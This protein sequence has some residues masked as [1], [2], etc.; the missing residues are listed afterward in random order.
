MKQYYFLSTLLPPLS[1]D[2]A[3]E[4]SFD[5]LVISL[6]DNLSP[7]DA[8]K[9]CEIRKFYDILNLRAF[10][11]GEEIDPR[12][13]MNVHELEEAIASYIGFPLY[14]YQFLENNPN[15]ADRI[16]HFPNL[17]ATF[18]QQSQLL[19]DPFLRRYFTFE[20]ALRLVLTAFRAKK[21]KKNFAEEFMYEDP[22]EELI[23]QLLAMQN[24][25]QFEP[26]EAFLGLKTL[27]EKFGNSPLDL[28]REIDRFRCETIESFI[29]PCDFFSTDR[30]LA[31]FAEYLIIEPWF[32]LD[33]DQGKKII[34]TLFKGQKA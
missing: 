17:L 11:K 29:D 26:P 19:K 25:P 23:A 31:Y 3:P 13:D 21:L 30:I 4:I 12:G 22:S 5:E 20:R 27:F 9:I 8:E 7:C 32:K 14:V 1:F 24:A 15:Q 10:F 18:F 2:A 16:D 34:D 28:Q 33:K 6:E